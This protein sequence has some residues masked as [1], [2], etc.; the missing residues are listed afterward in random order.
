MARTGE[1]IRRKFKREGYQKYRKHSKDGKLGDSNP[2]Y[3]SK[4]NNI[5]NIRNFYDKTTNWYGLLYDL[6]E[7]SDVGKL[8]LKVEMGYKEIYFVLEKG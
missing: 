1:T 4:D 8:F 3:C 2:W 6:G 7:V 5:Q